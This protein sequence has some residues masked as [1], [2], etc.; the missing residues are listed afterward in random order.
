MKHFKINYSIKV[1][2]IAT[3]KTASVNHLEN[4]EIYFDDNEIDNAFC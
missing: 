1:K 3:V 4:I 2:Q